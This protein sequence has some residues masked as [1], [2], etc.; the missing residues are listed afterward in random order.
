MMIRRFALLALLISIAVTPDS[1]CASSEFLYIN[2]FE[3]TQG[4][5]KHAYIEKYG[6]PTF[7]PLPEWVEHFVWDV[8][9]PHNYFYVY[10]PSGLPSY[11]SSLDAAKAVLAFIPGRSNHPGRLDELSKDPEMLEET[12]RVIEYLT[13][14]IILLLA[15]EIDTIHWTEQGEEVDGYRERVFEQIDGL[16]RLAALPGRSDENGDANQKAEEK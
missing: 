13:P 3:Y 7:E 16:V 12:R 4:S 6:K 5:M 14:Q 15:M 1:P 8:L 11:R 9:G 10:T 2:G